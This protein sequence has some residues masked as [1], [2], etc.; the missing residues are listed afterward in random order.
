[1]RHPLGG[2]AVAHR[3]DLPPEV[4]HMIAGHSKEGDLGPQTTD[5][6]IVHHADFMNFEP[7][8]SLKWG[9]GAMAAATGVRRRL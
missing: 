7:L 4:I 5:G 8:R 3:F 9:L 6:W 2:A 1:V